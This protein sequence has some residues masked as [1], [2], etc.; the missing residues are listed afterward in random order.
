MTNQTNG[1]FIVQMAGGHCDIVAAEQLS[2]QQPES[3]KTWGPYESEGEAIARRV[4]L[5]RSG[6]C[7][8]V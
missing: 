5:I 6:Q 4:G 8:P 2:R 7:K 3:S 1:W